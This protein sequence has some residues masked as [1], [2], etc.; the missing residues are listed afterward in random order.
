[1]NMLDY[2]VWTRKQSDTFYRGASYTKPENNKL[3]AGALF[4]NKTP[5]ITFDLFCFFL[6]WKHLEN[7][8][9]VIMYYECF[10]QGWRLLFQSKSCLQRQSNAFALAKCVSPGAIR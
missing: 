2:S 5:A 7:S 1:M 3:V 4:P 9:V 10:F 6:G 8:T